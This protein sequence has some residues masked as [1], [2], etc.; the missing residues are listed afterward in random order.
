MSQIPDIQE[1]YE[2]E[3]QLF[4]VYL[5]DRGY[6]KETQSAYLHDLKH[7]LIHLGGKNVSDATEIDVMSHLT[8]VRESGSGS[9]YRNRRQSTIRLFYKVMIRFKITSHNPTLDI[10]KAKVEK[11]RK[12]TYLQKPF[13]DACIHM[14]EGRYATRDVTIIALMAHAGLRVSEIVRLNLQNFDKEGKQLAVL[15]KG[16]KW[17]YIP[18]PDEI[19]QLLQL[20]ID[21]RIPPRGNKDVDAFF[22]SQF[23]RRISKRMVQC[24]AEKTF[25]ALTEKYPQFAGLSLSA[26]KLRHSFATDL[27]RNGADLR[28]VQEL[29]GHEDIS[30]TQIYTHVLD[31]AKERAMNKVRPSIPTFL[32]KTKVQ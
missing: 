1:H 17:R 3:I 5:K 28:T 29:L 13:L 30:T 15:G 23:R 26:H 25:A 4:L 24:V 20:T 7:F 27:L 19:V 2:R 10:E 11:N 32:A 16:E 14:I 31:E 12:P 21:D 18:L 9:R 6:S 22:I 8:Q